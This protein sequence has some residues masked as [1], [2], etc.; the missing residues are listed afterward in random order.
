[1]ASHLYYRL[2]VDTLVN[3]E[4]GVAKMSRIANFIVLSDEESLMS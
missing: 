1:M 2:I 4:L 3:R